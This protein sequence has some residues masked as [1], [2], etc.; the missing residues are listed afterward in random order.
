MINS[1]ITPKDER[2]GDCMGNGYWGK[3]SPG[4]AMYHQDF[5]QKMGV[6]ALR[7]GI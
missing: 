5:R 7:S 6:A 1:R 2:S 3:K 4:G